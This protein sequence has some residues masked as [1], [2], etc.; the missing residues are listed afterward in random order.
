MARPEVLVKPVSLPPS[1]GATRWPLECFGCL[2]QIQH[3]VCGKTENDGFA[4]RSSWDLWT[5]THHLG[6][7]WIINQHPSRRLWMSEDGRKAGWPNLS[8]SWEHDDI[9]QHPE[10]SGEYKVW[11]LVVL[12]VW[13]AICC[14]ILVS[15]QRR[16]LTDQNR[17]QASLRQQQLDAWMFHLWGGQPASVGEL[18]GDPSV[19]QTKKRPS[20]K[21]WFK[22]RGKEKAKSYSTA[23]MILFILDFMGTTY[24]SENRI[25]FHI[26]IKFPSTELVQVGTNCFNQHRMS[27]PVSLGHG[28]VSRHSNAW[29]GADGP[30]RGKGNCRTRWDKPIMLRVFIW[31]S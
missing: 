14:M 25:R 12:L 29:R 16:S 9:K 7:S 11:Y 13:C 4:A 26:H 18:R 30:W 10:T 22:V 24:Y 23:S 15:D 21:V 28:E 27:W 31:I 8:I 5:E 1:L 20:H 3:A 6:R 17:R 2:N 19:A